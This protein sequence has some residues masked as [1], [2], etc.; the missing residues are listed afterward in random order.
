MN[1]YHACATT[2]VNKGEF[3]DEVT[4]NMQRSHW[5]ETWPAEPVWEETGNGVPPGHF[6]LGKTVPAHMCFENGFV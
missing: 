1:C 5:L 3:I 2:T 6:F 4:K